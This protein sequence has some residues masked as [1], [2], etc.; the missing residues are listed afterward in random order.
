MHVL[1]FKGQKITIIL[2]S[3]HE[4]RYNRNTFISWH[5]E[6]MNPNQRLSCTGSGSHTH[7]EAASGCCGLRGRAESARSEGWEGGSKDGK[8]IPGGREGTARHFS[9]R[10]PRKEASGKLYSPHLSRCGLVPL[11][12]SPFPSGPP[13][14]EDREYRWGLRLKN[15]DFLSFAKINTQ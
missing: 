1:S 13:T 11:A 15:F 12:T 3:S 14:W 6:R 4:A 7:Q 5:V 10:A 9:A 2:V 8:G